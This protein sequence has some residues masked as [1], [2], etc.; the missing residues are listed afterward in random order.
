MTMEMIDAG[1]DLKQKAAATK[2]SYF[3]ILPDLYKEVIAGSQLAVSG[4]DNALRRQQLRH[5]AKVLLKIP[6]KQ[7]VGCLLQT[8]MGLDFWGRL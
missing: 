1:S 2:E 8:D 4:G 5:L 6:I 3:T 7:S